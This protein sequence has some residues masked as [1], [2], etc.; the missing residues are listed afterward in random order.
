MGIQKKILTRLETVEDVKCVKN[1]G[2]VGTADIKSGVGTLALGKLGDVFATAYGP[3]T[4]AVTLTA[5]A[6]FGDFVEGAGIV[7][8]SD[9]VAGIGTTNMFDTDTAKAGQVVSMLVSGGVVVDQAKLATLATKMNIVAKFGED[10][11]FELDP[12]DWDAY[13]PGESETITAEYNGKISYAK[14]SKIKVGD[15]KY[16]ISNKAIVRLVGVV[17]NGLK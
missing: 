9:D 10:E 16:A 7:T 6:K 3:V 8:N 4:K 15:D 5:N 2:T 1:D 14:D 11:E 13:T 12:A 17:V